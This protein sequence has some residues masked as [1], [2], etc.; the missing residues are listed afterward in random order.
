MMYVNESNY[1]SLGLL[2]N[3]L[4][5]DCESYFTKNILVIVLC[6]DFGVQITKIAP[7]C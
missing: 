7:M 5:K 6:I 2:D 1:L 4:S 3:Y